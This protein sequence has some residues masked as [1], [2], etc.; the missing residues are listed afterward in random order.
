MSTSLTDFLLDLAQD[1]KKADAFREDPRKV[2][3]EAGLSKEDQELLRRGDPQAIKE[4]ID[5]EK[6]GGEYLTIVFI[7]VVFD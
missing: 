4:A 3:A 1:P 6:T 7:T 2:M 5:T